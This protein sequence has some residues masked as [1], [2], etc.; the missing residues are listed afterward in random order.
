[1]VWMFH[2]WNMKQVGHFGCVLAAGVGLFGFNI[3]RTLL[4]AP[5]WNVIA[6]K[7]NL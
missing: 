4:R 1:M 3:A 7:I 6:I 5:K 2:V